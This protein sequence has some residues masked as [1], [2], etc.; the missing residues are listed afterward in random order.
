MREASDG[1]LFIQDGDQRIPVTYPDGGA[2]DL[3]HR[4]EAFTNFWQETKT[5]AVQKV[6]ALYK[7]VLEQTTV[8]QLSEDESVTDFIYLVFDISD[9][10]VFDRFS[11]VTRTATELNEAQ[12]GKILPATNISRVDKRSVRYTQLSCKM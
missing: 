2:V 4:E 9:E 12:F 8:L 3:N 6:D 7:I 11:R 1:S 5:I 10:G